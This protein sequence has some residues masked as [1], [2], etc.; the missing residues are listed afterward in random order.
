MNQCTKVQR[1]CKFYPRYSQVFWR[2]FWAFA[3]HNVPIL[4]TYMLIWTWCLSTSMGLQYASIFYT[5]NVL[6]QMLFSG[7]I[8]LKKYC[9]GEEIAMQFGKAPQYMKCLWLSSAAKLFYHKLLL[10]CHMF[11]G[12][13]EFTGET[14][15]LNMFHFQLAQCVNPGHWFACQHMSQGTLKKHVGGLLSITFC[16]LLKRV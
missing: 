16:K 15:F 4:V 12:L 14:H 9:F 1:L 11:F 3:G 2:H 8:L 13:T 7:G 10:F 5:K 6:L